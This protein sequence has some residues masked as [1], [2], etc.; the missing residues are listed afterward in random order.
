MESTQIKHKNKNIKLFIASDHAGF[1][2]KAYLKQE[3]HDYFDG[4][5]IIDLGTDSEESCDYPVYA[6]KLV[7]N[8]LAYAKNK[9]NS[10]A[11][12]SRGVLICG[13]GIGMSIAANRNPG[14]RAALCSSEAIAAFSRQHNDAN[15]IV[16]GA[17]FINFEIA[18][19]CLVCFLNTDFDGGRHARRL[20]LINQLS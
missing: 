7:K 15:V 9:E 8:L 4:I 10:S 12:I 1:L 18:L 5:D 19:H 11:T 17:R 13:S 2:L 16:F 14:I 3:I 20:E 6:D